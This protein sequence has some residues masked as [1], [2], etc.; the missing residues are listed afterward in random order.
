MSIGRR[1]ECEVFLDH[2]SPDDPTLYAS[3]HLGV[4]A[5]LEILSPEGVRP[6]TGA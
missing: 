3:D 1:P 5:T 4:A 2:P 6:F